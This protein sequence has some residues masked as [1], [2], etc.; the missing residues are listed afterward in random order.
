MCLCIRTV[1]GV[2]HC[3]LECKAVRYKYQYV[4]C[5]SYSQVTAGICVQTLS[6]SALRGHF[7]RGS[8]AI[9][10]CSGIAGIDQ[11]R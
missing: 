10:K 2:L 8:V 9:F 11:S 3:E 1:H 7:K 4:W 6:V 5:L